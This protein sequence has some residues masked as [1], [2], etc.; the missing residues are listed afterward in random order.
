[1]VRHGRIFGQR[2]EAAMKTNLQLVLAAGTGLGG[3]G[4]AAMPASA[5]PPS[6]F[7]LALATPADTAKGFENIRWIRGPYGGCR[8]VLGWR[9]HGWG[10]RHG[11]GWG[12]GY[13]YGYWGPRRW[14][15]YG[16]GWGGYGHRYY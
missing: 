4:S 2:V 10:S 1:M 11:S 5:M 12:A 7:D 15:P 16:Y 9:R 14:G 3:L 8:W 13:G 6:G